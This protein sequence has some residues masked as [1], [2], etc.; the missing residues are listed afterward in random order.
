MEKNELNLEDLT[1]VNGGSESLSQFIKRLN[2]G[3]KVK[4][5]VNNEIVDCII[6]DVLATSSS[7]AYYVKTIDKG[8]IY[9]P[10]PASILKQYNED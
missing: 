7:R 2:V 5:K 9:G 4:Y 3:S 8:R 1:L 6:S 10:I